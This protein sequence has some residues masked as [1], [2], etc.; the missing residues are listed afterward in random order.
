VAED[1]MARLDEHAVREERGHGEGQSGNTC[2]RALSH[3]VT[4]YQGS[5]YNPGFRQEPS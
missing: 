2:A 4:E 3:C 5:G 1:R